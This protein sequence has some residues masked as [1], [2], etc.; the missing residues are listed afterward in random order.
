MRE[1][2]KKGDGRRYGITTGLSRGQF[3]VTLFKNQM[4]AKLTD[5][6]LVGVIRREF[7]EVDANYK[8]N[9]SMYRNRFNRGEYPCQVSAPE[10]PTPEFNEDGKVVTKRRGP[11][12]RFA[13]EEKEK[14]S[15]P[16]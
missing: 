10:I 1:E 16:K 14:R 3:V 15:K 7:P 11:P 2:D 13:W 9:I 6:E 4:N 8:R 5:E 12:P